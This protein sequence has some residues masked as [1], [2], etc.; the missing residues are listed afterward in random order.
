MTPSNIFF[1]SQYPLK[2]LNLFF[3][4][5]IHFDNH[6]FLLILTNKQEN[7]K[8]KDVTLQAAHLN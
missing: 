7:Y 4:R 1:Y 2:A 5:L 6:W 8:L 3:V